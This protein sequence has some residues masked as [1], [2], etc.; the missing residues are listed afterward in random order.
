M[1]KPVYARYPYRMNEV[2][3]RTSYPLQKA[4][5]EIVMRLERKIL[6]AT[7]LQG[8]TILRMIDDAGAVKANPEQ[9][10]VDILA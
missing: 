4:Q 6:D 7:K 1:T 5:I 10:T 8:Q 9:G 3:L 2:S